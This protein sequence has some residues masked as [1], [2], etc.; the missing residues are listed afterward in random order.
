MCILNREHQCST[1]SSSMLSP[2][3][4]SRYVPRLEQH[5]RLHTRGNSAQCPKNRVGGSNVFHTLSPGGRSAKMP[6]VVSSQ[7][8]LRCGK[9]A[10][11]NELGGRRYLISESRC[12]WWSRCKCN[13][14]W[15][16]SRETGRSDGSRPSLD[17]KS[18]RSMKASA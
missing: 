10:E 14:W 1:R 11:S 8:S 17:F 7:D 5:L 2:L 9:N 16:G 13:A 3:R 15:R 4:N 12:Q 6:A 18:T